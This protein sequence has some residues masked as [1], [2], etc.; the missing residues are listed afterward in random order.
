MQVTYNEDFSTV[1]DFGVGWSATDGPSSNINVVDPT[2]DAYD[3][4][5]AGFYNGVLGSATAPLGPGPD[6][7]TIYY[8]ASD[9]WGEWAELYD[10]VGADGVPASGDEPLQFTGYYFT[11]NFMVAYGAGLGT[12]NGCTEAFVPGCVGECM[13]RQAS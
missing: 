7:N 8:P 9:E 5:E 6:G 12:F 4:A 2:D 3:E 10:P 11:Y 1:Q 13:A